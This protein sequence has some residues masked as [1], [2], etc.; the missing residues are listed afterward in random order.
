MIDVEIQRAELL[1][2][3]ER[4]VRAAADIAAGDTG[5]GELNSAAGDQHI[6]D[7]ASDLLDRQLD[8]TIGENADAVITEID[9]ALGRIDEGTYGRCADC[10]AEIPA[11]RLQAIPYA[12]LCLDDKHRREQS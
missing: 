3:R 10:G 8:Q 7:H 12:T 1:R 6:A 5:V 9:E 2:L 11:E 4:I